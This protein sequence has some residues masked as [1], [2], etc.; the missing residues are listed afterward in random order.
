MEFL[1]SFLRRHFAGKPAVASRYLGCFRK[2][3]KILLGLSLMWMNFIQTV[4]LLLLFFQVLS[5]SVHKEDDINSKNLQIYSF[6][7]HVRESRFPNPWTFACGI[8]NPG[9]GDPESQIQVPLEKNP[10]LKPGVDSRIQDC[11]EFLYMWRSSFNRFLPKRCFWSKL[12]LALTSFP[13][14]ENSKY[15]STNS[16]IWPPSKA[17]FICSE[18]AESTKI[19]YTDWK[20][21]Y[22]VLQTV[23]HNL[24]YIWIS[25]F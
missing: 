22:S 1:R 19:I 23:Q 9:L 13:A 8:R 24:L 12:Y 16:F 18:A 17:F 2:L 4:F 6:L 20:Y 11:L 10:E 3:L 15:G 14:N 25:N 5:L 21:L 7:P